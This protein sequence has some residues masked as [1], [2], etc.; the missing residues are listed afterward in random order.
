M[1]LTTNKLVRGTCSSRRDFQCDDFRRDVVVAAITV[2]AALP[3]AD[4][5]SVALHDII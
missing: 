4:T 1:V 5:A 2:A 3:A